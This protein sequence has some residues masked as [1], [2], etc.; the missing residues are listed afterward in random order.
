M[1]DE[2]NAFFDELVQR[3]FGPALGG[4][5]GKVRFEIA[6]VGVWSLELANSRVKHIPNDAEVDC[7]IAA[8]EEDFRRLAEGKLNP[9][10]GV[11]QRRIRVTGDI[12]LASS[13]R[14][15]FVHPAMIP[16]T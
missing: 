9:L 10:V 3:D 14:V 12:G 7:I 8:S 15:F 6:G 1:R 13:L 11:F 5:V 2:T 16:S 4:V